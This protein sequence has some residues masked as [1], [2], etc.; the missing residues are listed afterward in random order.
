MEHLVV[1]LCKQYMAL[2]LRG[3]LPLVSLLGWSRP[4]AGAQQSLR[5]L[6][7]SADGTEDASPEA[8][9][10]RWRALL[11]PRATQ[12]PGDMSDIRELLRTASR[13]A[14]GKTQVPEELL[15]EFCDFYGRL[16]DK[17]PVLQLLAQGLGV[18]GEEVEASDGA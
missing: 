1:G 9:V 18:D 11:P 17:E 8:L 15:R 13:L 5:W 7:R 14:G 10:A 12:P 16:G 6:S 2:L 3:A 4:L